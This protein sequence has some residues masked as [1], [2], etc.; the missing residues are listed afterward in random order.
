MRII[1]GFQTTSRREV[2]NYKVSAVKIKV[3]VKET[4]NIVKG[5]MDMDS[6]ADTTVAGAN[7]CILLYTGKNVTYL[8]TG[9]IT[10]QKPMFE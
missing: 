3:K 6:H 7:S 9:M 8:H 2:G 5:K 10:M 1:L 4:Y